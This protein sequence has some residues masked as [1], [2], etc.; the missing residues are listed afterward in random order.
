MNLY[1]S[2]QIF[3]IAYLR[4]VF[5][6]QA[7]RII[8]LNQRICGACKL[9]G[10]KYCAIICQLSPVVALSLC[11]CRLN[12]HFHSIEC[13]CSFFSNEGITVR[14]LEFYQSNICSAWCNFVL[15][16]EFNLV[17]A[18]YLAPSDCRQSAIFVYVISTC[19]CLIRQAVA[20]LERARQFQ[21]DHIVNS[22][23]LREGVAYDEI[24]CLC[25]N[26][27][28]SSNAFFC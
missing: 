3:N 28:L 10:Y 19:E 16:A 5:R 9:T 4:A 15:F 18:V 25:I 17:I 7:C 11:I 13:N 26:C 1:L 22:C 12:C 6:T 24:S 20:I 23:S 21:V 27:C 8:D 14:R 2:R